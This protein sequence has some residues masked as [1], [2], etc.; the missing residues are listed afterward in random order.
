MAKQS[1]ETPLMGQY[2]D[3]K[4]Q[5]PDTILL[6]RVGD[7][8][9]TFGQD[10][11]TAAGILG[12]VLTSR[13]NGSSQ[14]ELAGFPYHSLDVYLPKLVRAGHRVAVCDQLEK[15]SPLKKIVKR[16]VTEVI[17]PGVTLH[18]QILDKG[19]NNYLAALHH[20]K[21]HWGLALVD[22]STGEFLLSQG[23]QNY[24]EKILGNFQP[25]ELIFAKSTQKE[26]ARWLGDRY[27]LYGLEEWIFQE[28]YALE[29]LLKQYQVQSLKGFG[30]EDLPL[31]QVAAGA[32]LHYIGSTQNNNLQHLRPLAR[33]QSEKYVWLDR[34][35]VRNLE[36]VATPYSNGKSLLDVLDRTKSPMGCRLLKKWILLPLKDLKPIQ[37]RHELVGQLLRDS[38]LRS[39][40]QQQLLPIGD[41]ER[42]IAKVPLQKINPRELKQLERA[43]GCIEE[44]QQLLRQSQ[45][46][47]FQTLAERLHPCSAVRLR[48]AKELVQDPPVK[49]EKGGVIADGVNPSLDEWRD[50]VKNSQKHLLKIQQE[51]IIA[52]GIDNLKVG[53]NNVFGY[54]L[55]VT[56][57]HKNKAEIPSHWV[58]KQTLTNCERY[59]TND[60]KVLEDKILQAEEQILGL[61]QQ[62]YTDLVF[63]IND[64]IQ[65]IQQNAQILAQL[66]CLMA[67]AEQAEQFDYCR[68][69]MNES[70]RLEIKAGRHPVI[71]RQ[72]KPG[73]VYVPNDLVLDSEEEQILM[74][75]GPNMA[76]KS[77]LL[78]QTALICLMAQMGSF[79]PATAASLGLVDKV[80]T[81]VG[82]SDNISSGESTFMVEMNET[83]SILNNLSPRSLI[84][85]DEIGRGTSTYDGIS[86]A[87]SI[88]EYLHNHPTA[89]AKTLFATHY[90]ELNELANQ[91]PRIRNY[92]I[93]TREVG[94]QVIFLRKLKAGGSAHSFGIH[95][96]KMAG[97]P[98]ELIYRAQEILTQLEAQRLSGQ[99]LK[100]HLPKKAASPQFQLNIF[101]AGAA[102]P[103]PTLEAIQ[104]E[105]LGMDVY[106]LTPIECMLKIQEWINKVKQGE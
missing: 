20:E 100:D 104:A 84:L 38:T 57:K 10:A 105:L 29:K 82:A 4:K 99:D 26:I 11:V 75:T 14:T 95:V 60:L 101:D 22:I 13:N 27:Y 83:A 55:E 2:N 67:F 53:F 86:I 65:A 5:Y 42:L 92:H 61:E 64:Y 73:E 23:D 21:Q 72:L 80:F 52:T 49:L 28:D 89:K 66:D 24:I 102:K 46:A 6:F 68:P 87:W 56:N 103:N 34:F 47:H 85:L 58:R 69:E 62:C 8:Y 36:L 17:T 37:Q 31:A 71:E 81:R 91:F 44:I 7:F 16:G 45:Q 78:R 1:T 35:T 88:A 32:V 97:M 51:E 77:A 3:I 19:S 90:H 76:G 30:V 39:N 43:L 94:H 40:L 18:D 54:Y 93:S 79:V 50:L 25:T 15:P 59:I 48:I 41:L 70:L 9:E 98:V 12:I 63:S 96:A 74:I 33:I 106:R